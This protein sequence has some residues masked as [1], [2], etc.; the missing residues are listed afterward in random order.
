MTGHSTPASQVFDLPRLQEVLLQWPDLNR[1][2]LSSYTPND[3]ILGRL[4]QILTV[5]DMDTVGE[6]LSDLSALLR[7]LLMAHTDTGHR[8]RIPTGT[9]WPIFSAWWE[10]RGFTVTTDLKHFILQ[11]KPWQ[12]DWVG[13]LPTNDSDIFIDCF[14]GGNVRENIQI[15][16]DPFLRELTGYDN[17]MSRGQREA[18]RAALFM[19]SGTTLIVNLPTG[20]GK[21]L[22]GQVPLFAR[23]FND[24]LTLFVVPTTA[25]ALD[26][27]RR[28]QEMLGP[29]NVGIRTPSLAWHSGLDDDSKQAIRKGI[30]EGTQGIVFSSPEAATGALLPSLYEAVG[31][32]LLRY[33][34]VDEAHVSAQW[35]DSFRP[36]FQ[37]LAGVRRGLLRQCPGERFRTILMSATLSPSSID[38]LKTLYGP[39]TDV[40]MVSSV[41]LRPEPRYFAYRAANWSDKQSRVLELLRHAPRPY[42][43]YV[44]EK[45]H[46][47]AWIQI[48]R[49]EGCRRVVQFHGDTDPIE[50]QA[51]IE[52]WANDRL[53]GVVATSAF[54]VGM[55]KFDVRTI[56]HAALPETLD[57]FYQEVGRGGRDGKPS[58]SVLVYT[59]RDIGIAE[60]LNAPSLISAEKAYERWDALFSVAKRVGESFWVVD[61]KI[62]PPRLTAQ[63]DFNQA[64]NVRTLILMAR[65][66][67]IE[68][69][70]IPFAATESE[71]GKT[72]DSDQEHDES[73]QV[74]Y[75]DHLVIRTLD[76]LHR[77]AAHFAQHIESVRSHEAK[78]A[79][80]SLRCL[81][82]AAEGRREMASTLA[83]L[84]RI[85]EPEQVIVSKVCRG[86]PGQD[87]APDVHTGVYRPPV[88]IG[89]R[90]VD[91]HRDS[92]YRWRRDFSSAQRLVILYPTEWTHV[93]QLEQCL[94]IL[95][96]RYGVREIA[97]DAEL[98]Q[99]AKTLQRLH[100]RA[101]NGILYA[102]QL[103][104]DHSDIPPPLPRATL[105]WKWGER[106]IPEDVDLTERPIHVILAPVSLGSDHPL[107]A[108]RDTASDAIDI[109]RFLEIARQ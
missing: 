2:E 62:V 1:D 92:L 16:T 28:M 86:C 35:G 17:Y 43:L 97:T 74:D 55:D 34:I 82:D 13:K 73:Y 66:G 87:L 57:R 75:F 89:I 96:A 18:I 69:D 27:E 24:G 78:Y 42:I 26:L 5:A 47:E 29:R 100:A 39:A 67:M 70:S 21:T 23:G 32:G 95:V 98:W 10:E 77:D 4:R 105:L 46:A 80:E 19:E 20:S 59:D 76:P 104:E 51:I 25:L 84:Y 36:E 85:S 108:Y 71:Q 60:S 91:L 83:D 3:G 31:R 58:I 90:R 49:E 99:R 109:G 22:A 11:P 7:H 41:H 54:G 48:L 72:D 44:T 64:W 81:R 107:R 63:T 94:E 33:L 106:P 8:L 52:K 68:I 14:T 40:Q 6:F 65:A 61:T 50:R 37:V 38:T 53:D 15:S 103:S 88:P 30:R 56:I 45:S 101:P 93:E 79:Q 9:G 102:S 12:P